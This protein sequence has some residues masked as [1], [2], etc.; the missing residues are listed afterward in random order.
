MR[1][2]ETSNVCPLLAQCLL[3]VQYP[4]CLLNVSNF[5]SMSPCQ[6]LPNVV[7]VEI[8]DFFQ[9]GFF[10]FPAWIFR[11][12]PKLKIQ[13]N[14]GHGIH[15]VLVL[16]EKLIHCLMDAFALTMFLSMRAK[17]EQENSQNFYI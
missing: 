17:K 15:V 16:M 14:V 3:D 11:M 6:Y 7:R 5:C 12:W 9:Y 8:S 10:Q 2:L 4:I 13:K 1:I